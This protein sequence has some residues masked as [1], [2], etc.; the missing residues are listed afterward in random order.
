MAKYLYTIS[1][2]ARVVVVSSGTLPLNVTQWLTSTKFF[3]VANINF[4]FSFIEKFGYKAKLSV[5]YITECLDVRGQ[6]CYAASADSMEMS[7][8]LLFQVM[9]ENVNVYLKNPSHDEHARN[10]VSKYQ[11]NK[12]L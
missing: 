2:H 6:V 5:Y 11:S 4:I 1:Q 12:T 9:P 10:I 3:D 8:K 7:L